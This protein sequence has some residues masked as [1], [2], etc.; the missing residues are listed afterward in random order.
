MSKMTN[1]VSVITETYF[2]L[3]QVTT[4]EGSRVEGYFPN[5]MDVRRDNNGA[6]PAWFIKGIRSLRDTEKFPYLHLAIDGLAVLVKNTAISSTRQGQRAPWAD[7]ELELFRL[8]R[9]A[10]YGVSEETSASLT[11]KA[12]AEIIPDRSRVG[13][14]VS[15]VAG[16]LTAEE[17]EFYANATVCDE[18]FLIQSRAGGCGC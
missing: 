15:Q 12:D 13:A 9:L 10:R 1:R 2:W 11:Y 18:C 4:T 16:G 3:V 8:S 17:I 14:T 6:T 5:R 7:V